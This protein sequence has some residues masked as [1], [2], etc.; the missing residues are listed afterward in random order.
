M[1]HMR[2]VVR[3][4]IAGLGTVAVLLATASCG[5]VARTGR[6][7]SLLIIQSLEA[8]SGA[9]PGAFGAFLLSDVQTLVER[10]VGGVSVEVPTI[11]DDIGEAT[12]RIELKDQGAATSV[13][14]P[15][16]LNQVV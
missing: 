16:A 3:S 14:A 13:A 12:L 2:P 4:S 1:L 10:T 6:S 8:A 15:A 11:F 9:D 7:P 5:D